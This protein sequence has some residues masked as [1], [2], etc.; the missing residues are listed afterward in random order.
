[1]KD[2]KR[3]QFYLPFIWFGIVLIIVYAISCTAFYFDNKSK[4]N[5][6]EST[7]NDD[8]RSIVMDILNNDG[9][10]TNPHAF[11]TDDELVVVQAFVK[12]HED[13][14]NNYGTVPIDENYSIF[15]KRDA[16]ERELYVQNK[17]GMERCLTTCLDFNCNSTEKYDSYDTKHASGNTFAINN[18]EI[19]EWHLGEEIAKY[20]VPIENPKILYSFEGDNFNEK[21]ILITNNSYEN[22]PLILL[23]EDKSYGISNNFSQIPIYT[24]ML[25]GFYFIEKDLSLYMYNICSGEAT[26]IFRDVY[27]LFNSSGVNFNSIDGTYRINLRIDK[28]GNEIMEDIHGKPTTSI[29]S[30]WEN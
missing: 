10:W 8:V 15:I 23:T 26:Y 11:L 20:K 27:E 28:N 18:N 13:V 25:N 19:V 7:K 17:Q 3:F 1:M 6:S 9:A 22:A 5:T 12:E 4:A 21:R 30:K 29:I 2:K 16:I 24:N 14:L